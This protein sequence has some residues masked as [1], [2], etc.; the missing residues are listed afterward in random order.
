MKEMQA[1]AR[2]GAQDQQIKLVKVPIPEIDENEVLVK[3]RAFGVGPN[4]L[5]CLKTFS[6]HYHLI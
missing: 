4:T 2:I 6:C 1:F 3:V 5:Q